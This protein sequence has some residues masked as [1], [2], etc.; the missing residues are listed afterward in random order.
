MKKILL[1]ILSILLIVP[2]NAYNVTLHYNWITE[3]ISVNWQTW[4]TLVWD[5]SESNDYYTYGNSYSY[6]DIYYYNQ[7]GQYKTE[8]TISD[9][10]LNWNYEKSYTWNQY[11]L[12]TNDISC[13]N[14][15]NVIIFTWW[16]IPVRIDQS[17]WSV[18]SNFTD[19]ALL[20]ITSNIP[21]IIT[22]LFILWLII[23]LFKILTPKKRR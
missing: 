7:Y 18:F 5:W 14:S 4:I 17:S 11:T 21:W 19:N 2:V 13:I 10:Y 6:T 15:W 20:L 8:R 1:L 9:V 12:L 16:D 3:V 22:A 23:F